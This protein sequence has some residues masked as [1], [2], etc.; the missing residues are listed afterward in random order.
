MKKNLKNDSAIKEAALL[1]KKL[2]DKHGW[3]FFG[4]IYR[5]KDGKQ[6]VTQITNMSAEDTL[7]RGQKL[8]Q[9][10]VEIEAKRFVVAPDN[11]LH[12]FN[13]AGVEEKIKADADAARKSAARSIEFEKQ[14]PRPIYTPGKGWA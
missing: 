4:Q 1:L 5:E 9:P 11:E 8:M 12:E 6:I 14:P 10:G 2:C 7:A 3:H 13:I